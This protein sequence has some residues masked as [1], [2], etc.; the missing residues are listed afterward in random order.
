MD[1]AKLI[2]RSKR[3]LYPIYVHKEAD[4]A[5]GISFPDF[6][7]CFAGADELHDIQ[8]SAQEA[9]E[10]HF[11]GDESAIPGPST[12]EK[13]TGHEDFQGGFWMLMDI[14]LSK[15]STKAVRLNISLPENLVHQIDQAAKAR[16]LSRS[17]FLAM[18][19]EHEMAEH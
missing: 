9:V 11:H 7:G 17:A 12:P 14:D 4:S 10:A 15:I 18:A 8:R 1:S 19:A 5:Y 16:H 13:W 6:P 2:R 3:V